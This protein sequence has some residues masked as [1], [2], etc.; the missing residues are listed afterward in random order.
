MSRCLLWHGWLLGLPNW[1]LLGSGCGVDVAV[2]ELR[3]VRIP[4]HLHSSAWCFVTLL[5]FTC[6]S[7]FLVCPK[8]GL[9]AVV[10]PSI[11]LMLEPPNLVPLFV[12]LRI[13]LGRTVRI[14]KAWMRVCVA[15]PQ[16]GLLQTVHRA[17]YWES[18]SPCKLLLGYMWVLTTS[19]FYEEVCQTYRQRS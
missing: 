3:L 5:K 2:N 16:S 14:S 1:C 10:T 19:L 7:W 4:L 8:F 13:I 17:E 11:T 12:R 18:S 9:A 6:R 15:L